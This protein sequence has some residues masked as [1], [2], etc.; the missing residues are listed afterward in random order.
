MNYRWSYDQYRFGILDTV[1][2][3][4]RCF[5]IQ[6]YILYTVHTVIYEPVLYSLLPV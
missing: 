1:T 4:C 6:Y 2:G 5:D 3:D